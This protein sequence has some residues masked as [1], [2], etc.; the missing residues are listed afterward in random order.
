MQVVHR[1]CSR[2]CPKG[3]VRPKCCSHRNNYW[4]S[5]LYGIGLYYLRDY[6]THHS[7]LHP[8]ISCT[9]I[10]TTQ[11]AIH[12]IVIIHHVTILRRDDVSESPLDKFDG[13]T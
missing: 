2:V 12:R 4:H 1:Y 10:V 6:I 13:K 7:R 9:I 11:I 8:N 5:W 3:R